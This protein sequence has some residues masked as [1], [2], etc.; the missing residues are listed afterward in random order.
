MKSRKILLRNK[1]MRNL[2]EKLNG[3]KGWLKTEFWFL[4][5]LYCYKKIASISFPFMLY[6]CI[7]ICLQT[8]SEVNRQITFIIQ[9][10]STFNFAYNVHYCNTKQKNCRIYIPKFG[11]CP[12]LDLKLKIEIFH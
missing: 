8:I 7:L 1:L 9:E 3:E 12:I 6:F 5:S 11:K 4:N 2:V 10:K